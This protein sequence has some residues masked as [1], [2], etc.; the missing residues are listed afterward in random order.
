[1]D[2]PWKIIHMELSESIPALSLAPDYEGIYLVFW[3]NSVPLGHC[4]IPTTLLPM[5]ATQIMNIALETITPA[6]AAR[7]FENRASA[8]SPAT[9]KL[10]QADAITDFH[11]LAAL[12]NPLRLLEEAV[13]E[14]AGGSVSVVICTRDRPESLARCLRA[15]VE[16][17]PAPHEILVVDNAPATD[18]TCRLVSQMPDIR[19]IPEPRPGLSWARNAGVRNSTGDIIA[20]TDDDVEFHPDWLRRLRQKFDDPKVISVTGLV[21]PAELQTEA[22]L[23]F[24]MSLRY[25]NKGYQ[26]RTFDNHFFARTKGRGVPAWEVGAGANMAIRRKAFDLVGYFDERLGAG[27]A[28]CSEDSEFWYRLLA[29]GWTCCYEPASVV[30]HYHRDDLDGLVRQMRQYYRGYV[31]ALLVQ[32]ERYR[33]GGNL[34][35]LFLGLPSYYISQFLRGTSR[36]SFNKILLAGILG[37]ISGIKF[38]LTRSKYNINSL[39]EP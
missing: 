17:S 11:A 14:P 33:H 2:G 29:E 35:R 3:W 13:M 23:I 32:F 18:A 5:N 16:L 39:C 8:G 22:Q 12:A 31:T 28:G 24:E 9:M 20:F 10:E 15:L 21:L 30:Y 4:E 36:N 7:L 38:Y 19:Y 37:A 1:M 34:L 26:P 27:A 25:L 6:V